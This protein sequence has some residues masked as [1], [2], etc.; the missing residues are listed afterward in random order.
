MLR[1]RKHSHSLQNCTLDKEQLGVDSTR[2]NPTHPK[3]GKILEMSL[4]AENVQ[5]SA[6]IIFMS[7]GI[8]ISKYNPYGIVHGSWNECTFLSLDYTEIVIYL[9]KQL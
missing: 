5:S 8:V 9:Q 1:K 4:L 7:H 6:P 3:Q 2:M